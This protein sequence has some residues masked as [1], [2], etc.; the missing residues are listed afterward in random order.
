MRPII[1]V[2]S[3]T[4]LVAVLSASAFPGMTVAAEEAEHD[5][6]H[7]AAATAEKPVSPAAS[8]MMQRMQGMHEKMMA[9]K[10]PAERQALMADHMK[11]MQEGMTMMQQMGAQSGKHDMS[12]MMQQR[13]DMMTRMMQ[14]MM[15]SQGA[16]GMGGMNT[17]P[18]A[19]GK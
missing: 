8:E 16:G 17:P 7:A 6:T 4:G 19:P 1:H 5:H 3:V 14:M 2:L 15:D 13:M 12:Q 18:A 11:L 10:T 9:A